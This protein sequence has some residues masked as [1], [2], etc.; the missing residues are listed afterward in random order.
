MSTSVKSSK[1]GGTIVSVGD[2]VS[3]RNGNVIKPTNVFYIWY[4][5]LCRRINS[6]PLSIVR[7]CKPKNDTILDFVAD[8]IKFNEWKPILCA[9]RNDTSLHVIAIRS[10]IRLKFLY[11]IDTDDKVRTL[12]RN[13]GYLWTD[14]GMR[15]LVKAL[16][17]TIRRTNVLTC[18]EFDG[19]PISPKYLD[20]LI[21]G[22][23][24]NFSLKILSFKQCPLM[25][26]GCSKVCTSISFMPNVEIL[27]LTAC[28]LTSI[29]TQSIAKMIR[30]QQ[31]SRYCVSWHHSLR[32]KD[33]DVDVLAGLK[34]ITLNNNPDIGDDGLKLILDELDDDLWIKAIDM[35]RC[36]ITEKMATR[37]LDVIDYSKSL[38]ILDLR[39]ND[40][41]SRHTI[42][43]IFTMLK[44]KRN[45]INNGCEFQ[46]CMS[47][48]TVN[49][50]TSTIRD[51][52][53]GSSYVTLN[54]IQKTK[55]APL[56]Q[57]VTKRFS[58][59]IVPPLRRTKTFALLPK[60][61]NP[62]KPEDVNKNCR[63]E[64]REE[65]DNM[66][67]YTKMNVPLI[68][69]NNNNKK[70]NNITKQKIEIKLPQT[71]IQKKKE[72]VFANNTN[73]LPQDLLEKIIFKD[74]N[75][76]MVKKKEIVA[77]DEEFSYYYDDGFNLAK[78]N[79]KNHDN[80]KDCL[81]DDLSSSNVSLLRY[82]QDLKM[83][84]NGTAIS[85]NN[86]NNK[87]NNNQNKRRNL[88]NNN[89]KHC[90]TNNNKNGKQIL[91][92]VAPIR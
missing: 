26:V 68:N 31:I 65:P 35:Q 80:N 18:L 40:S 38:E 33:P 67:E 17:L 54:T 77:E 36:N 45:N 84:H 28:N 5:E 8:R 59:S 87:N 20:V 53:A 56:K 58:M 64:I 92:K 79:N 1:S 75:K 22:L 37:I 60:R 39:H 4:A 49:N 7:P 3:N 44:E 46:W 42:E 71:Q 57:N 72:F 51:S 29:C 86:N 62:T 14:I 30:H 66:P 15:N 50:N 13:N 73:K 2:G 83:E 32:Y 48:T 43:K 21:D 61:P 69:K 88:Q 24:K 91:V 85:T 78:I 16:S 74:G 82:M 19:I 9:L 23:K 81:N 47:T 70:N 89:T 34:R 27:N 76:K 12:K 55:S 6:S 11:D 52:L 25:D 10:R 41:L 90:H 63:I